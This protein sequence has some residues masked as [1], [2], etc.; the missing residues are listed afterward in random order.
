MLNFLWVMEFI[1]GRRLTEQRKQFLQTNDKLYE[2][3]ELPAKNI[4]SL[5]EH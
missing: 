3:V 2:G 1:S 5:T 4:R